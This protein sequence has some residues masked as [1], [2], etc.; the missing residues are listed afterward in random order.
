MTSSFEW[1]AVRSAAGFAAAM[2]SNRFR[3]GAGSVRA[4]VT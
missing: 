2:L 1:V 4:G 3:L